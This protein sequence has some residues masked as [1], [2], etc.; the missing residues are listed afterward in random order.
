MITNSVRET[1]DVSHSARE[2]TVLKQKL[3]AGGKIIRDVRRRGNVVIKKGPNLEKEFRIMKA[4][5]K[6]HPT[7]CVPKVI[8]IEHNKIMMTVLPGT[9][10]DFGADPSSVIVE[11]VEAM[12]TCL[13]E[14]HNVDISKLADIIDT[15]YLSIAENI[16]M[17]LS[18]HLELRGL[19]AQSPHY[20][21][22]VE[23]IDEKVS[24]L[25]AKHSQVFVHGDYCHPQVL[26]SCN[27]AYTYDFETAYIGFAED[28][29]ARFVTKLLHLEATTIKH[30]IKTAHL[31]RVFLAQYAKYRSYDRY[32]FSLLKYVYLFRIR[33]NRR[34][35]SGALRNILDGYIYRRQS[36]SLE[37]FIRSQRN[38]I[39]T[40]SLGQK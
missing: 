20:L 3:D 34:N 32:V 29:L 1:V 10:I 15:P 14:I 23:W 31:E 11:Q 5:N 33:I 19:D 21:K 17:R 13:A 9:H 4:L 27:R 35:S 38:R 12:A 2:E 39:E 18:D 16:R 28:D 24:T 26:V 37:S 36:N 40:L 7:L 22:E 30:R 8:S 25:A 6:F